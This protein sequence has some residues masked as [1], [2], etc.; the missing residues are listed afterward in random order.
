MLFYIFIFG[1]TLYVSDPQNNAMDH[2]PCTVCTLRRIRAILIIIP[3]YP[4]IMSEVLKIFSYTIIG[5][6]PLKQFVTKVEIEK[7]I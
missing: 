4:I 6:S 3:P 7:N 2:F 5:M 1:R